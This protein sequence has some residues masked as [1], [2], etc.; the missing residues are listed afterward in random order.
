MN[1][2]GDYYIG[3]D[4][5]TESVGWAVTDTEYNLLRFRRKNMWGAHLFD[6][7]K[8]AQERRVA[9]CARRRYMR[10]RERIE[11]SQEIFAEEISKID[12][13][14]FIRLNDSGYLAEDKT[15]R[16]KNSLFND[17]K[18][19]DKDFFKEY[20][21]IFHLRKALIDGTARKDPRLVYLAIHHIMKNRGH[22]L[23]SVG[24]N[25]AAIMNTDPILKET[26]EV[27]ATV[28]DEETISFFEHSRIEEALQ[29]RRNSD[30]KAKL[31]EIID[32]SDKNLKE[33]L[34]KLLVGYKVETYK[35]FSNE[36]YEELPALEF[37]K[38]TFED[39]VMPQLE[40]ALSAEEYR[41]VELLK[42][43]Y[44]WSILSKVLQGTI[45]ISEAKIAQ[46]NKN[47]EDL[48]LLKKTIKKYASETEYKKYF[49]D[50]KGAFSQ[51]IGRI[52][53]R[54]G[55][56]KAVR[57]INPKDFCDATKKL[58]STF[59]KEDPGVS[60]VLDAIEEGTFFPLLI[61]T[62]N[63]ILPYQLHLSELDSIINAASE[64][65]PFLKAKD[66]DGF[67]GEEKLKS[68]F[69]FRVPYYVGPIGKHPDNKNSWAVRKQEG[70]VHP[71]TFDDFIDEDESAEKFIER[72]TNKC[73]YL[74][75]QDVIP[76]NS[77][78]YTKYMVLNELNNLRINGDKPSVE[79]KQDIYKDLFENYKKITSKRLRTY[80]VSRGWYKE[81]EIKE[82]SGIDGD[83]KANL[84]PYIMFKPYFE[85][86][87]LKKSEAEKIIKW[88][89]LFSD[90]GNMA[91]K[92][93]T[94]TFGDRLS[95][96][97]IIRI[98]SFKFSGWGRFS[99]KFLSGLE[100]M[101]KETGELDT[102]IGFL[103]NSQNN[104]MELLSSN[105]TFSEHTGTKTK[106]EKL[107]Y[108]D[109]DELYV[110]PAV[111]RQIWQTLRIVDEIEHIVGHAPKKVF[112]E[113][114][115]SEEEKK[116]TISRKNDLLAKM[117]T[118]DKNDKGILLALDKTSSA[119]DIQ[120]DLESKEES[121]I[122]KRDRLYLYYSQMGRCMYSG[123]HIDIAELDNMH[124]YDIDHIYPYSKSDDDSLT[125]KVLVCQKYNKEKSDEYPIHDD[126]RKK[127]TPFWNMLLK[128]NLINKEKF[129]R[130]TRHTPLTDEDL[131]GFIN[132][133]LVETTQSTKATADIL[134]RYF[135]SE[136][137]IVYT[138][139]GK[140][141]DFRKEFELWKC[142]SINNL[143]HA[144]DA[145]L[146]IVV[147]NVLDTKY[148]QN[149][150]SKNMVKGYQNISTPFKYDVV[151]AWIAETDDNPGSMKTVKDTLLSITMEKTILHTRQ[152]IMRKGPLFDLMLVA[153]GSKKGALP[154]KSSDPKYKELLAKCSS[155]S[156][157]NEI[158]TQ[159][160]GGYNSLAVSHF[161]LVSHTD[162]K[163]QV[164]SFIPINVIDAKKLS[165]KEAIESYCIR[166]LGL[167]N[168]K[169][170]R[171]KVL[172][173]TPIKLD[174]YSFLIKSK[175]SGGAQLGLENAIPLYLDNEQTNYIK[176]LEKFIERIEKYKD[177]E[178]NEKFDFIT[179]EK[180]IELFE[181]L[182]TKASLNI[183][184]SRPSNQ[185][186]SFQSS[187]E[188]FRSLGVKEQCSCIIN[189]LSYFAMG[190]GS[191]DFSLLGGSKNAGILRISAK[192]NPAEK[193]LIIIDES[194][195]GLFSKETVI[196]L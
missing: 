16:Q 187:L 150:F 155:I 53:G 81:E 106:I 127:M 74:P 141:S 77:L 173:N 112:V 164:V 185:F 66:N 137:K 178:Y 61:S 118:L 63:S 95:K 165:S 55:K 103:W 156:E 72:M 57:R 21:T 31:T 167:V 116:R 7:A 40:A 2:Y 22:F 158:W 120:K 192:I 44:D 67:T 28:F 15:S 195:T 79:Q 78:L 92:R 26:E 146:N 70:K 90:G 58:F 20:P 88:L 160:Y 184:N 125:N 51:Y 138:K 101:N 122:S 166:E 182:T 85:S 14:F 143:H 189:V 107:S 10:K 193:E 11:L 49:Y 186:K 59:P 33:S 32:G 56:N 191:A 75:D 161:A 121:L 194:I 102:I 38:A 180:N 130:L 64:Y 29:E 43:L 27:F 196:K 91:K 3:L 135:G 174:K 100:G 46:Y 62:D 82:I 25:I 132:R 115:R 24:D 105:Y 157:A 126:I 109:V 76:K 176:K 18:Y 87:K 83:F 60:Y 39:E 5:G 175:V 190:S 128:R 17:E 124:V 23:F 171:T 149:F 153:K 110:S 30:K 131:K 12:P 142:R 136:T 113:V 133:Q 93:I 1:N 151:N 117:K 159:K 86:G 65:L 163:K 42:S 104:L 48:A 119:S 148:T 123:E 4:C 35:L 172:I 96:E 73:V 154:A 37:K 8:T 6:E 84:S 99:S 45:S 140:V 41:L 145:Y 54:N 52:H 139:A 168:V 144:K 177:Y 181:T 97:D 170:I 80:I 98:S 36:S 89:T 34:I 169:T 134:K 19:T 13:E 108:S 69:K 47:K 50:E 94:E 111:K 9:R 71:W 179:V 188:K 162:R 147:G 68:I 152:P 183:N 114:A 129:Y